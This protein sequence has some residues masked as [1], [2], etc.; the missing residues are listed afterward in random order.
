MVDLAKIFTFFV[1]FKHHGFVYK[2]KCVEKC[3]GL[4]SGLP[5]IS[6]LNFFPE[7]IAGKEDLTQLCDLNQTFLGQNEKRKKGPCHIFLDIDYEWKSRT[8]QAKNQKVDDSL[9]LRISNRTEIVPAMP[10][11]SKFRLI[12]L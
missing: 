7:M 9:W 6:Q 8:W 10:I 11:M 12:S 1:E 5:T 4:L 3:S 2:Q